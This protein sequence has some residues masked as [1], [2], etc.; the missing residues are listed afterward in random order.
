MRMKKI[1]IFL[2]LITVSFFVQLYA[3]YEETSFPVWIDYESVF[4]KAAQTAD[5]S[6]PLS[7]DGKP[8]QAL[9][10]CSK[11]DGCVE[12]VDL[13]CQKTETVEKRAFFEWR[14]LL[15]ERKLTSFRVED[16]KGE[17]S[18]SDK[19]GYGENGKIAR[20]ITTIYGQT[21]L[22]KIWRFDIEGRP[23]YEKTVASS[24]KDIHSWQWS[25]EALIGE[26]EA[27]FSI[28]PTEKQEQVI[29][30][31]YLPD[32]TILKEVQA[33]YHGKPSTKISYRYQA[34]SEGRLLWLAL[35]SP[36]GH[37]RLY[38]FQY[39]KE[40]R[41]VK[42]IKPDG[43]S[44]AYEYDSN[45]HLTG[46]FSSD[47]SVDYKISYDSSGHLVEVQSPSWGNMK[48]QFS[49]SKLIREEIDG[50]ATAFSFDS[51]GRRT[52]LTL[53]DQS[54]LSYI[55]Q[56]DV[57]ET[58]ARLLPDH[59]LL[60]RCDEAKIEAHVPS[61][62]SLQASY[63]SL[64]QLSKEEG[65]DFNHT[66]G[67]DSLGVL[68]EKDGHL[69]ERN[70][71]NE[72]TFDGQIA[73]AYDLNGRLISKEKDGEKISFEWDGLDR[74]VAIV[75]EGNKV[76][77]YG[78]DLFF[79]RIASSTKRYI[80]DGLEEI[81]TFEG[82]KLCD[83]K[84]AQ[85]GHIK[86]IELDGKPFRCDQDQRGSISAL[87]D[88][89]TGQACELY[90]YSAFGEQKIFSPTKEKIL[91]SRFYNPWGFCG[92]RHLE[93]CA[94]IDFGARIYDPE[95]GCWTR[96]DPL[97]FIDGANTRAFALNDPLAN[98]DLF[99]LFVLP[100][101]FKE[102]GEQAIN[103]I[104]ETWSKAVTTMT[105]ARAKLEWFFDF[106]SNFEDVAFKVMNKT[107][108]QYIGYNPDPSC[109]CVYGEQECSDKIRLTLING[110]LNSRQDAIG[111]AKMISEFHG[112]VAIHYIYAATYG[113]TPDI[114]L[115]AFFAKLGFATEQ[116]RLLAGA[117]KSLITEMGG[118]QSGGIIV[119]YAHSRGAIDTYRALELLTEEERKMIRIV[120]FGSAT[121][122][123]NESCKGLIHY[124]S[125]RDIWPIVGSPIE[126]AKALFTKRDDLVFLTPQEKAS[127]PDHVMD[128]PD[129]TYRA[130][131]QEIGRKFQQEHR[132]G[133]RLTPKPPGM[134]L[135]EPGRPLQKKPKL[136]KLE[137]AIGKQNVSKIRK[138]ILKDVPKKYSYNDVIS[139]ADK[140][141]YTPLKKAVETSQKILKKDS[142]LGL[143]S[144]R[145]LE[146]AF[147]MEAELPN[148]IKKGKYCLGQDVTG[149]SRRVEY[150]PVTKSRFIH[151][152]THH[153]PKIGEG[154]H[155]SVTKSIL[156]DEG[157]PEIIANSET[158]FEDLE[159]AKVMRKLNGI[160]G[161]VETK[162]CI[163]NKNNRG[164]EL[165]ILCKLYN[166]GSLRHIYYSKSQK[167]SR[168]EKIT[169]GHDLINGLAGMH[170]NSLVH[171]DLHSG[172]F[173]VNIAVD[174]SGKRRVEAAICDFGRTLFKDKCKGAPAQA[175]SNYL[176]PESFFPE[177]LKG[178]DYYGTDVYA[179]GCMLYEIFYEKDAPWF[180][181][182]CFADV[183]ADW[184]KRQQ[185][186]RKL[187]ELIQEETFER[188]HSL[189]KNLAILSPKERFEY[190]ILAMLVPDP[191]KRVSAEAARHE[192][193][194]IFM[195]AQAM[196]KDGD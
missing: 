103:G 150:D 167:F 41:L 144:D 57:L 162:A 82:G 74:M 86:V 137:K 4:S 156:Y 3:G 139:L 42:K 152:S 192:M 48:R 84:I 131:L 49:D 174:D 55:Y 166:A 67:F 118:T 158:T 83:L 51:K 109:A 6:R 21:P 191:E 172:N 25:K 161:I 10:R 93:K 5:F 69:T 50:L 92:K 63:D 141:H 66:F 194:G 179:L 133:L 9:Y 102:I 32:R 135:Q 29:K 78:Y 13:M 175:A 100:I 33:F 195:A 122:A 7:I 79:R 81:A 130:K 188:R 77:E 76:E 53:P 125:T 110:I 99:G 72:V 44:I 38:S 123:G 45:N 39:D 60:Y 190:L 46:V 111:N 61:T 20:R 169:I 171:R 173:I 184:S 115:Y 62:Q 75:K 134:Y 107:L 87:F 54:G 31:S 70:E 47:K 145:L 112:D 8:F 119:H 90:S 164:R 96:P 126:I 147:F 98:T 2:S 177:K 36:Q 71:F 59:T 181:H 17:L 106:R 88:L 176:S 65:E 89:E 128:D 136:S 22:K 170:K 187:I 160:R 124:V 19:L 151:L 168:F 117:W 178:S 27:L 127:F 140:F 104:K 101:N 56:G 132:R 114:F 148:Y 15:H 18:F 30:S 52:A 35:N 43:V 28:A 159:E 189:H 94:L 1:K 138:A 108:W 129:S 143:N 11:E 14:D 24:T 163:K 91:R 85:N 155:K 154:F 58:I 121:L 196:S 40:G 37:E 183:K 80:W 12:E 142:N 116:A 23:L 34:D 180:D 193:Q 182:K 157:N 165:Q 97:H 149:L 153:I 113:F 105:F 95:L 73:Y 185:A 26:E 68:I 186:Q 64:G 146:I 120:T 16:G